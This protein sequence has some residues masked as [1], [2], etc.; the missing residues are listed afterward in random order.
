MEDH[1]Q[2]SSVTVHSLDQLPLIMNTRH[3]TNT[4]G[5]VLLENATDF[6]EELMTPRTTCIVLCPT[7]DSLV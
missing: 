6:L 2:L 3:F 1:A 7:E 5:I 4:K